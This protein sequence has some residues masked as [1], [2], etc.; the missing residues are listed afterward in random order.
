MEKKSF[1]TWKRRRLKGNCRRN[2]R[3][4]SGEG[5]RSGIR[6]RKNSRRTQGME[7][8]FGRERVNTI[9]R[10]KRGFLYLGNALDGASSL[11]RKGEKVSDCWGLKGIGDGFNIGKDIES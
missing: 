11:K 7:F 3:S 4:I 8:L 6:S 10:K 9:G 5:I 1:G 2:M